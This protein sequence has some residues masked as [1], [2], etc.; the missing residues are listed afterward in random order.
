MHETLQGGK[1][2]VC[3]PGDL[4][5]KSQFSKD[6]NTCLTVHH[7]DLNHI[8]YMQ[9]HIF[10]NVVQESCDMEHNQTQKFMPELMTKL[11]K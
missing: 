1:Q 3:F 5:V 4:R 8:S 10:K 9:M 7:L 11:N 2:T 6:A